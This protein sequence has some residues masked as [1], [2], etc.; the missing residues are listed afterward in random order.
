VQMLSRVLVVPTIRV[1]LSGIA[2][3]AEFGNA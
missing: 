3:N 1:S 2:P